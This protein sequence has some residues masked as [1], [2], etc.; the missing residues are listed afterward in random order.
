VAPRSEIAAVNPA[1]LSGWGHRTRAYSAIGPKQHRGLWHC[2][3]CFR[4]K[5]HC[6]AARDAAEYPHHRALANTAQLT[7]KGAAS[8]ARNPWKFVAME[9][10]T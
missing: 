6:I 1:Y 9:R 5:L 7:A 3:A 8:V 10:L 2:H 4:R